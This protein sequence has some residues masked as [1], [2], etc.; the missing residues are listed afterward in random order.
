MPPVSC[1]LF[2]FLFFSEA[3]EEDEEETEKL[4][5]GKDRGEGT[6]LSESSAAFS[7]SLL[8]GFMGSLWSPTRASGCRW[9]ILDQVEDS[10]SGGWLWVRW[11]WVQVALVEQPLAGAVAVPWHTSPASP[12][13]CPQLPRA[14]VTVLPRAQLPRMFY[15]QQGSHVERCER[16]R[17]SC[18]RC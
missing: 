16:R 10:G 4:Q 11:L 18:S 9:M 5:N 12:S 3:E 2:F 1:L 14:D 17:R 8:S 6:D 7:D 15:F 13:H